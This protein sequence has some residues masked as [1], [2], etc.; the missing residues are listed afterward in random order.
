M[1]DVLL[2][3]L[4]KVKVAGANK[5]KACCPA[6]E[7]SDPSLSIAEMKDG[8]ILVHCFAGC[9]A[10]DIVES[11][12]LALGDLFPNG[13]LGEYRGYETIKRDI[14]DSKKNKDELL[15]DKAI[16]LVAKSMRENGE[17]LTPQEIE[18]EKQAYLRVR[19]ANSG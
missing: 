11:I 9:G 5:W 6:H 14:A 7:D 17:R 3:R 15:K 1:I 2:S 18:Q 8:R 12:G 13:S 10:S 16:L 4:Q 19:D